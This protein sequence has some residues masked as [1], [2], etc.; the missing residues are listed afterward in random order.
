MVRT[1]GCLLLVILSAVA[2]ARTHT[3]W[4]HVAE[5]APGALVAVES[6][7][8]AGPETCRVL[9]VSDT[10]LTCAHDLDPNR[11][12][13]PEEQARIVYP[14]TAVK[15]VWIWSDHS[16]RRVLVSMAIGFAIGALSCSGIGPGAAFVCAGIGAFIGALCA[17]PGLSEPSPPRVPRWELKLWYRAPANAGTP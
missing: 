8:K 11:D 2:H 5:L 12:W 17:L 15:E 3:D 9:G 10:T 6:F 4:K 7:G 1:A 14:R 16:D 13:T